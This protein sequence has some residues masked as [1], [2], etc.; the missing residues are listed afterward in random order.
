MALMTKATT[1]DDKLLYFAPLDGLTDGHFRHFFEMDFGGPDYYMSDFLRLPSDVS[2]SEEAIIDI[3]GR[4]NHDNEDLRE[5]NILQILACSRS[6]IEN[7]VKKIASLGIKKLNL[8]CG[9]PS[10]KVVGNKGGSYLL[11]DPDFFYEMLSRVRENYPYE[12]SVK[13]RLGIEN[14]EEIF[15]LLPAIEKAKV[16]G[17][18]IH[19]RTVKMGYTGTSNWGLMEKV[20][21]SCSVPVIGNGDINLTSTLEEYH[22]KFSLDG[23]MIGRGLLRTPWMVK[24]LRE[25]PYLKI[26]NQDLIRYQFL[27]RYISYLTSKVNT[28]NEN[29]LKRF[30]GLTCYLL[31]KEKSKELLRTQTLKE[32]ELKIDELIKVNNEN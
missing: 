29:L 8:N 4:E 28:K 9:C 19:G 2:I 24:E 13:V 31:L 6:L 27:K 3:F 22:E 14:Q 21:E 26:E 20:K 23:L 15:N 18:F 11:S 17:L 10:R 7:D 32:F 1:N 12:F 5:K 30:K 25:A 16:D